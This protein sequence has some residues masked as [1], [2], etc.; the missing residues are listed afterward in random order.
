MTAKL[1]S[2]Q[3]VFA[4]I[5]TPM[6]RVQL[7]ILS[8]ISWQKRGTVAAGAI[9]FRATLL[10]GNPNISARPAEIVQNTICQETL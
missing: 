1:N 8:S 3:T 10:G 4:H 2:P 6:P 7:H 5:V 9:T